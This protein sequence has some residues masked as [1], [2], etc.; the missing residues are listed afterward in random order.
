[1]RLST[2]NISFPLALL[3]SCDLSFFLTPLPSPTL[4]NPLC[5][6]PSLS[7]V[8][9]SWSSLLHSSHVSRFLCSSLLVHHMLASSFHV[10]S[11]AISHLPHAFACAYSSCYG[12]LTCSAT[13]DFFVHLFVASSSDCFVFSFHRVLAIL[14]VHALVGPAHC[15]ALVC[16]LALVNSFSRFLIFS[17]CQLMEYCIS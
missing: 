9:M 3:P 1:M 12:F 15:V 4:P 10:V 2:P 16:S 6:C 7:I 11:R 13:L 14:C 8:Q 5:P 17:N